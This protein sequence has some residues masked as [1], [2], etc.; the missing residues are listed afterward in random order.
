MFNSHQEK[1]ILYWAHVCY[2]FYRAQQILPSFLK[3]KGIEGGRDHGKKRK[4]TILGS[5]HNLFAMYYKKGRASQH[6]VEVSKPAWNM[7]FDRQPSL[8]FRY[9]SVDDVATEVRSVFKGPMHNNPF[10]PFTFNLLVVATRHWLCQ[11]YHLR[12]SGQHN[13]LQSW[14]LAEALYT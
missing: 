5:W 14:L 12:T 13:R 2:Y 8:N 3:R 9:M 7:G 10:L 4:M 1:A 6:F 11:V